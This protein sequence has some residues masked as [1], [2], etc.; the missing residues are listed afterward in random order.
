MGHP[1]TAVHQDLYMDLHVRPTL[2]IGLIPTY[3]LEAS[4]KRGNE[5]LL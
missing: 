5:P 4:L 1:L 3:S 2:N